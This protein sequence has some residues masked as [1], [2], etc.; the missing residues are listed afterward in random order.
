MKELKE[1]DFVKINGEIFKFHYNKKPSFR[2]FGC[3][4]KTLKKNLMRKN[5]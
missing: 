4:T 1:G 5:K 2:Y 3:D